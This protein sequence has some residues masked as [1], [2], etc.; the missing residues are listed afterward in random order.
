MKYRFEIDIQQPL[1]SPALFNLYQSSSISELKVILGN[2]TDGF[3]CNT[4]IMITIELD[5]F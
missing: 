4:M 5:S 1:S 2:N 3:L